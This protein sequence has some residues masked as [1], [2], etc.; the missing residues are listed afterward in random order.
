MNNAKFSFQLVVT[1][2]MG[3]IAPEALGGYHYVQVHGS[4]DKMEGNQSSQAQE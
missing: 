2:R 4:G 1:D 3:S